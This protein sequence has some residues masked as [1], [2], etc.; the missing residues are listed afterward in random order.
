MKERRT[1]DL[2][3]R[4]EGRRILDLFIFFGVVGVFCTINHYF[5]FGIRILCI[6]LYIGSYF[7]DIFELFLETCPRSVNNFR[8]NYFL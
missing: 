5:E 6:F 3:A 4:P 2:H 7:K 8:T 1:K